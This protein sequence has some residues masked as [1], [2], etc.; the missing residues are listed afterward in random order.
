MRKVKPMILTLLILGVLFVS[1][2]CSNKVKPYTSMHG[3]IITRLDTRNNK[4][5]IEGL[6]PSTLVLA[7]DYEHRIEDNTLYI[8]VML[9]SHKDGKYK[10]IDFEM[11]L[12][13]NIEKIFIEDDKSKIMIWENSQGYAEF[14]MQERWE[15]ELQKLK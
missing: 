8:K 5:H 4:V 6:V 14:D 1:V 7:K 12:P 2:S 9:T 11:D 13:S 15:N 10:T 3:Q